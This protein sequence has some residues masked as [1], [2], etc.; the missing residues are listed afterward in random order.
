MALSRQIVDLYASQLDNIRI[1]SNYS[2]QAY[3][4]AAKNSEIRGRAIVFIPALLGSISGIIVALGG[5]REFGSIG[6]VS[7]AVAA[8]ASFLGANRNA[9]SLKES[10]RQ[11]TKMRHRAAMELKLASR[12]V[13]E[14]DLNTTLRALRADYDIIVGA[15]EPVSGRAFAK[16][17]KRIDDGVLDYEPMSEKTESS[18]AS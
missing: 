18:S 11:F 9:A 13:S 14:E 15:S 3:F 7:G 17:Q 5:A 6:A 12:K 8:T 2:A 16:A 4:E 10:A 1:D